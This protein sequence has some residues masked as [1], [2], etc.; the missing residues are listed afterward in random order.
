VDYS[1]GTGN[2]NDHATAVVYSGQQYSFSLLEDDYD[3]IYLHTNVNF[4]AN[5]YTNFEFQIYSTVAVSQNSNLLAFLIYGAGGSTIGPQVY[6]PA[7]IPANTWTQVKIPFSNY[8][9]GSTAL[10][11]VVIQANVAANS[12][13]TIYVTNIQLSNS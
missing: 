10:S 6:P 5:Q 1:W 2:Y 8:G 12:G 7:N 13:N 3:A 11:G 9:Q 4:A